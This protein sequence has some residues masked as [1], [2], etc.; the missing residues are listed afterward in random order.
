MMRVISKVET[1]L[2]CVSS[3]TSILHQGDGDLQPGYRVLTH[4]FGRYRVWVTQLLFTLH[5]FCV[6]YKRKMLSWFLTSSDFQDG[7]IL[8]KWSFY[9]KQ[10][11]F[12]YFVF[13]M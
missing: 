6:Y 4:V 2:H 12:L 7:E 1:F 3:F 13:Y 11:D 5:S 8:L 10:A 9:A